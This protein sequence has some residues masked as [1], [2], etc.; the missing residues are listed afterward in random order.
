MEV[1]IDLYR[2]MG[3]GLKCNLNTKRCFHQITNINAT[4]GGRWDSTSVGEHSSFLGGGGREEHRLVMG[5]HKFSCFP[6]PFS[7]SNTE[8]FVCL[9]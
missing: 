9:F 3:S 7:Q 1:L 8:Q 6:H 5:T 2:A 4:E